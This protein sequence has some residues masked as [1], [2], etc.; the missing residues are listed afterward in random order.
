[1][2][3]LT[4]DTEI[5]VSLVA[6]AVSVL[7]TFFTIFYMK[8]RTKIVEE[9]LELLKRDSHK[10][11]V[12]S[13]ASHAAY[14]VI[15]TIEKNTDP[16][17]YSI[18]MLFYIRDNIVKFMHDRKLENVEFMITPQNLVIESEKMKQEYILSRYLT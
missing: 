2:R 18:P 9:E 1:M 17:Q 11:G 16:R 7:G 12:C 13:K 3:R 6:I 4:I 8:K 15:K 14:Q 10:R 5:I